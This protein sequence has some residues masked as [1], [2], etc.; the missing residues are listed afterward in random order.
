MQI[1]NS[2]LNVTRP[3]ARHASARHANECHAR[4]RH[5]RDAGRS[6]G[7]V[8]AALLALALGACGDDSKPAPAAPTIA[9]QPQS[10]TVNVGATAA[11]SVTADGHGQALTYQWQQNGTAITG[12]T[13]STYTTPATVAADSGGSFTVVVTAGGKSVTSSAAVLT[14]Q[15][16]GAVAGTVIASDTGLALA[17]AAVSIGSLTATSDAA[18]Q[19][20][21]AAVPVGS[22]LVVTFKHAGYS[23]SQ[24]I[25]TV[26]ADAGVATSAR[27]TPVG[28][29]QTFDA[30]AGATVTV[31]GSPAQVVLPAGG[32]VTAAGGAPSG[33]VTA[34]ITPINPFKN[35]ANM[36]G[37]YSTADSAGNLT[38]IESFGALNVTLHDA[39]G[40]DV[41]LASGQTATI[42]IPLATN[43]ATPPATAPLFYFNAATGL[44]VS[45]GTATLAGTAPAQYYEGT[46]SHFSTW[47]SD[48]PEQSINV[49][50]CVQDGTGNPVQGAAIVSAGVDYTGLSSNFTDA[51]GNF[52]VV[53]KK[54]GVTNIYANFYVFDSAKATASEL[55]SN[56]TKVSASQT[57]VVLSACLK[58]PAN[59]GGG[60]APIILVQPSSLS[61]NTGGLGYLWVQ[62]VGSL[63][64][65]IQWQKDGVDIG[66]AVGEV[67][68]LSPVTSADQ[69]SYRAV[70]TNAVGS[71]NSDVAVVTVT[72]LP[73]T[74]SASPQNLTVDA[75]ATATFAVQANGYGSP[76][77]YQWQRN[78]ADIPGATAASYTTPATVVGDS[79]A[80]FQAVVTANGLS[81][82]SSPA[83]LT[84]QA[85]AT[86]VTIT[87]QPIAASVAVGASAS[88]SVAASGSAPITY[89]WRRNGTAIAAATSNSYV[90]PATTLADSGAVFSVVVTNGVGSVTSNDATLTVTQGGGAT[91]LYLVSIAGPAVSASI[92]YA[93]GP[94]QGATEALVAV[95]PLGQGGTTTL[96]PAG[97]FD[98]SVFYRPGLEGTINGASVTNL[99]E[100]LISYLKSDG[101]HAVDLQVAS[102]VPTPHIVS[103]LKPGD[104]CSAGSGGAPSIAGEVSGNDYADATKSWAFFRVPGTDGTCGTADDQFRAVRLNMSP[105]D[106]AVVIGEPLVQVIGAGGAFSGLIV[107]NGNA[108]QQLDAN[109]ANPTQ[110]FTVASGDLS[111]NG[112]TFG[113]IEP[114]IWTYVS[115]T[116]VYGFKVSVNAAAGTPTLLA[117][118]ASGETLG[119]TASDGADGY[120]AIRGASTTR[121]IK[122]NETALAT[123]PVATVNGDINTLRVSPTR[124]VLEVIAGS[125]YTVV[126]LPKAGGA[127]LT[128]VADPTPYTLGQVVL[129][130]ENVYYTETQTTVNSDSTIQFTARTGIVQ[131]DNTNP[132]MLAN[133]GIAGTTLAATASLA[134]ASSNNP[135]AVFLATGLTSQGYYAGSTLEAMEGSTR[136]VLKIYGQVQASPQGLVSSFGIPLQYGLT[137]LFGFV[138]VASSGS[139]GTIDLYWFDSGAAN[140]LSK[141]TNF[142]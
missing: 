62:A 100:R 60:T 33:Q 114:G 117:T 19:F 91:G 98:L 109:L 135:Y 94:S 36:P 1:K 119:D 73:P 12:A 3:S 49:S 115:G 35:P 79:G 64:I 17:G 76:L 104:V 106:T 85:P 107:R 90:T 58:L 96:E 18:G 50:G 81:V 141:Q 44:W 142:N 84:V 97:S 74:I 118:L 34:E 137:G 30:A 54:G 87:A 95:P 24:S 124:L 113:S 32:F 65:T 61:V 80:T 29:T 66:G 2:I 43:S 101:L 7:I 83:T 46:V 20:S 53:V 71:T 57:D 138:S 41:N 92:T 123:T 103:T 21:M 111:T 52:I 11:F 51:A 67:L 27:L 120:F 26:T 68:L 129:S 121:I 77:T 105:T 38:K 63:P 47:N 37:D 23:V 48:Q 133:V 59:T 70:A 122:A 5:G 110:L 4:A 6:F 72:S 25:V 128:L 14:V 31:S 127:P 75:G 56:I 89:Q 132:T 42:R 86:P 78:G 39:S 108:I 125:T 131:T 93:D 16:V 9:A 13:T 116:G 45:E 40:N 136:S 22:R 140:S 139:A 10:L 88:F 28:G 112:I 126:S 82:T 15:Q 130:G 55:T 134:A 99:H 102:G 69:G 8:F